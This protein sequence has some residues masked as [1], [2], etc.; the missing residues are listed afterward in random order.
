MSIGFIIIRHVNSKVSDYYWKECYTCIRSFYSNPI[1][2]IDDSSHPDF[3]HENIILTNCTVIYD[4]EHKGC[5]EL[6][7]YYYLYT[8]KPFDIAVILHDSV[9]IQSKIDISLQEN[10]PIRFLWTI[11]KYWDNEISHLIYE[12]CQDMPHGNDIM[13]LFHRPSEWTG[14]F[15][16]MSIVRQDFIHR[17]NEIYSLFDTLL[18]K[19]KTRDNRSALERVFALLAH[20]HSGQS[21]SN[22]FGIIHSYIRWGVTF[23][24]YLTQD[25]STYPIV[26]VW[27]GR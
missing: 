20:H 1:L 5:A 25:F 19:L 26:K 6:L 10:E 14:C 16:V 21:I 27:S 11:P 17:M 2:I 12:L 15:G 13:D 3:L 7:P 24:D 8:L 18:P 23:S 22:Q 9:F 4:T